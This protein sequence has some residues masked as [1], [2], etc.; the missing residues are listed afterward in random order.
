MNQR[1]DAAKRV[2]NMNLMP[3]DLEAA[4]P[5]WIP[6]L[7]A[8]REQMAPTGLG[9]P[10]GLEPGGELWLRHYMVASTGYI[11]WLIHYRVRTGKGSCTL[12]GYFV[13]EYLPEERIVRPTLVRPV[14]THGKEVVINQKVTGELARNV[15]VFVDALGLPVPVPVEVWNAQNMG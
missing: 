5:R 9:V 8:C 7:E 12:V 1:S 4:D 2:A 3:G 11:K 14:K 6:I 13:T 15:R 10:A